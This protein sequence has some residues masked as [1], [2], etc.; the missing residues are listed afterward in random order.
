MKPPKKRP[1][2]VF[3]PSAVY[4]GATVPA[5]EFKATCLAWLER[6]RAG[7]QVVI[8]KRGVPVARLVPVEQSAARAF[9]SMRG[10]VLAYGD[11][12]S[13]VEDP[14]DAVRSA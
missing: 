2:Q 3:E 10:T 6:V 14:W 12:I 11:L 7:E 9:G 4:A 8:T 13:P 1:P 5:T